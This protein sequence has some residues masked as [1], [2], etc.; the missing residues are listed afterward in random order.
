MDRC[1]NSGWVDVGTRLRVPVGSGLGVS[2]GSGPDVD[3]ELSDDGVL[4]RVLSRVSVALS[5][6]GTD[7]DSPQAAANTNRM[8]TTPEIAK[9][10]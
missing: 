9:F 6:A 4:R 3:S 1:R 8:I 10:S 2:I 7:A 5:T